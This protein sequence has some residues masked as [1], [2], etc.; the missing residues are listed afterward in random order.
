M[1]HEA[2][3]ATKPWGQGKEGEA[4]LPTSEACLRGGPSRHHLVTREAVCLSG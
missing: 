4:V 2:E 3:G 1:G